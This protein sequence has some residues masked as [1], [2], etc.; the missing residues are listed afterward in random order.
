MRETIEGIE[1]MKWRRW[2]KVAK[3]LPKSTDY[4]LISD[5]DRVRLA[6]FSKREKHFYNLCKTEDIEA[7][8]WMEVP[9]PPVTKKLDLPFDYIF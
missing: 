9:V 4:C 7:I 1:I 8:Y 2:T 5:G 3:K 6:I